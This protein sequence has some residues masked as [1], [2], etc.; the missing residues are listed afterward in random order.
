MLDTSLVLSANNLA[1]EVG[2]YTKKVVM[3]L[4]SDILKS[5]W[6]DI[7]KLNLEWNKYDKNTGM[8]ATKDT[9]LQRES[10]KR[11]NIQANETKRWLSGGQQRRLL[12]KRLPQNWLQRLIRLLQNR[13]QILRRLM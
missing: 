6:E 2:S 13:L 11:A 5:M 8:D 7:N 1:V 4:N 10:E 3:N 9:T 12:N